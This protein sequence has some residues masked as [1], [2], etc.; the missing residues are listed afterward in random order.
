MF[1]R[2]PPT[3]LTFPVFLALR[4]DVNACAWTVAMLQ[5]VL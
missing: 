2:P 1:P 4:W 5:P 3:Q